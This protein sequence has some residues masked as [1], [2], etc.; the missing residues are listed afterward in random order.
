MYALIKEKI[1][2]VCL[3]KDILCVKKFKVT[4]NLQMY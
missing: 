2:S 1:F 3:Y 4:F